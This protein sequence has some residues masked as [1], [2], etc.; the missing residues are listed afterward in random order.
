MIELNQDKTWVKPETMLV[1]KS[2]KRNYPSYYNVYKHSWGGLL[3]ATVYT[4]NE[5]PEIPDSEV[6]DYRKEIGLTK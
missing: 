6:V 3:D 2:T 1:L 4:G 5:V